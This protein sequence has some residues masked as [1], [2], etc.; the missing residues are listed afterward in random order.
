MSSRLAQAKGAKI[1]GCSSSGRT[2]AKHVRGTSFPITGNKTKTKSY[3][4]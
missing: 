3:V 1:W 4:V 2:L